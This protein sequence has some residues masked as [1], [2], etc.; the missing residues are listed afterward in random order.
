MRAELVIRGGARDGNKLSLPVHGKVTFGRS[1]SCDERFTEESFSR[2][3]FQIEGKGSFFLLTD[4]QSSTGTTV[5]GKLVASKILHSGDRIVAGGVEFSFKTHESPT[6]KLAAHSG[7][8][9]SEPAVSS[10]HFERNYED[11]TFSLEDTARA[12][13][14]G[15]HGNSTDA[16]EL[17][18]R[19]RRAL[20]TVYHVGNLVYTQSSLDKVCHTIM[21]T[22]MEVLEPDRGF[23]VMYDADQKVLEPVVVRRR[24]NGTPGSSRTSTRILRAADDELSLCRPIVLYSVKKGLSVVSGAVYPETGDANSKHIKSA[25]CVPVRTNTDIIGA[26]YLDRVDNDDP[27]R[28]HQLELLAAIGRQAGIAIERARMLE[29]MEGLFYSCVRALVSSIEAKDQ[30]THGH[31]E[32]VT[33]FA[34]TLAEEMALDADMLDNVRLGA[35]LHD[36]GK[37]GVA[38]KILTKPSR[39]TPDEVKVIRQHPVR[40]AEILSH[41]R[42]IPGVVAAVKYHHEMYNG[43]GYPDGLNGTEVPQT[44]RIVALADAFDAMTSNRSYRRNFDVD[45]AISEFTRCSGDQFDPEVCEVMIKLLRDGRIIPC[46][47]LFAKGIDI[48]KSIY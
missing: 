26:I 1:P 29:D 9:E 37:I 22:A 38:E 44:A 39:L 13:T 5:N 36:V 14:E 28:S 12:D 3:H 25:M 42:N 30:Y 18:A 20:Q 33:A 41:I 10:I 2:T 43:L 16:P 21:D 17:L 34:V 24:K 15:D 35:L 31:S 8:L 32:R 4:L 47:E 19:A 48:S 45:E 27:F 11:G 6:S 23:L 46:N 40:G 7:L